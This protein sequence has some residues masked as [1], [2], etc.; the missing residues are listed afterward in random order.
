MFN[1]VLSRNCNRIF[2]IKLLTG[3]DIAKNFHSMWL[4][5]SSISTTSECI[6]KHP[7]ILNVIRTKVNNCKCGNKIKKWQT[8]LRSDTAGCEKFRNMLHL[9]MCRWLGSESLRLMAHP[10]DFKTT[11]VSGVESVWTPSTRRY[12]GR[13]NERKKSKTSGDEDFPV[14]SFQS[15]APQIRR[16]RHKL[17]WR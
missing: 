3:S 14:G 13:R 11:I 1:C 6:K 5:L 12:Y 16:Q 10:I 4:N 9:I 15:D 8:N 7:V 17:C 2:R